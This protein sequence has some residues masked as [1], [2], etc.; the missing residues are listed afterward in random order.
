MCY[1]YVLKFCL[2]YQFHILEVENWETIIIVISA[3][4]FSWKISAKK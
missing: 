1:F 4:N 2:R 3:E